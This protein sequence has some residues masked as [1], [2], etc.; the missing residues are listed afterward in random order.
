[1]IQETLFKSPLEGDE[2]AL[3]KEGLTPEVAE[4]LAFATLELAI[5]TLKRVDPKSPVWRE[6]ATWVFAPPSLSGRGGLTFDQVACHLIEVKDTGE[7]TSPEEMRRAIYEALPR[8]AK[9]A[10]R[11]MML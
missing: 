9:E 6:D 3:L 5:D 2:I 11:E 10:L 4:E 1:M 7:I 8:R